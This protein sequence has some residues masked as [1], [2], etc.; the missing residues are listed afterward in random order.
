[1]ASRRAQ[2][3]EIKQV[4]TALSLA[5]PNC[6]AAKGG[7]KKPLK[8]GIRA[9][10]M[11]EARAAFP[12]LSRRLIDACL[13]DYCCGQNYLKCTVKGATRV[14]LH[15]NFA[16]F[17]TDDE[18]KHALEMLARAAKAKAARKTV[19]RPDIGAQ[20]VGVIADA[21]L[22]RAERLMKL[23]EDLARL[24][25]WQKRDEMSDSFYFTSGRKAQD[26]AKIR[27]VVDQIAKLEAAE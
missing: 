9:D 27:D 21:L 25:E 16:G 13:R 5:F 26:E 3:Q 24:R 1:M 20:A 4:R 2:P 12:A 6:F 17:V 15:G 11:T 10:F 7:K 14:D 23:R 19:K 8:I 18:A 22:S